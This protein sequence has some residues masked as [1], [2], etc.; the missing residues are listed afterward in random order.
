MNLDKPMLQDPKTGL[1]LPQGFVD[2]KEALKKVIDQLVDAA[3]NAN[4]HM[5]GTYFLTLQARFDKHDPGQFNVSA[6]IVTLKIP[7]FKADSLVFWVNNE[8]SV[9]EL[10]WMVTRGR[11]KQL[12]VEFNKS[13]VAYLQAKG[14][15]P[16]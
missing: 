11:R 8:K 1:I 10:L 16:S 7:P 9:C 4:N 6:P 3:V 13:G 12:K 15:M 5:R 2:Q 14:A